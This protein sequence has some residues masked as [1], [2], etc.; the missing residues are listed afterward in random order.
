MPSA[1][2]IARRVIPASAASRM[3]AFF[4]CA[5][6]SARA[7]ALATRSTRRLISSFASLRLQLPDWCPYVSRCD[8]L[9]PSI[10]QSLREPVPVVAAA[11][12]DPLQVGSVWVARGLRSAQHCRCKPPMFLS[13]DP[14]RKMPCAVGVHW[15]SR[16]ERRSAPPWSSLRGPFA[17]GARCR[18]CTPGRRRA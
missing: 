13:C 8:R 9:P 3:A 14:F 2:A 12:V 16:G 4:S 1:S 10:D 15:K 7:S 6:S 18:P 11:V 5:A 17:T